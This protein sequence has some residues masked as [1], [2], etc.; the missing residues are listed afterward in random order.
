MAHVRSIEQQYWSL[1]QQ[2]IA[3]WSRETAVKLGE[4]I[5]RRERAELEVGRATTADV[6]E[7]EQQLENFKL[8]LVTA[9]SDL[10]TT[11]RQLRNILGLSSA[12]NRRIVP[13]TAPTEARLEPEWEAALA[14]MLQ[15]IARLDLP[16]RDVLLHCE[17]IVRK[18]SGT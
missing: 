7:A 3:L 4:E 6:A 16:T 11:E 2:Q 18:S 5:L 9:T 10:I 1:S 14:T 15:R 17:L 13:D 12:D 8:N